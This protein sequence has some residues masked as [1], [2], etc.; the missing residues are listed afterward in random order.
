MGLDAVEIVMDVEE[1][2]DIRL[3]DPKDASFVQDLGLG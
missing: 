1:A 2:F 3:E